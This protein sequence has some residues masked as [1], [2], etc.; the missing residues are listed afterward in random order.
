MRW[1]VYYADGSMFDDEMGEWSEAPARGVI[2]IVTPDPDHGKEIEHGKDFY[3]WWPNASK[4]WGVD[5][6]GLWDYLI[7]ADDP[8]KGQRVANLDL[9]ALEDRVKFGRS[10]DNEI[11]RAIIR[12]AIEDPDFGKK[13]GLKP[14]ESLEPGGGR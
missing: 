2:A 12:A 3:L 11:Y 9:A 6:V 8:Q 1:R 10:V 5:A 13:T 14:G 4:P 7:E